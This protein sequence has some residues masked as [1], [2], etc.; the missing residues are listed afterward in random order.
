M[1]FVIL[2]SIQI[3]I[4]IALVG[5]ILVQRSEGG[6]LGMGGGPSG[7]MSARGAGNFLT[8]ATSIL[9][10]LFFANCIAL[11]VVSNLDRRGTSVVDQVGADNVKL[12]EAQ[13]SAA[14]AAAAQN[15][16]QSTGAASSSAAP[17]LT[18]LPSPTSAAPSLSTLGAPASSAASS[19]AARPA[20]KP[21][22]QPAKPA[23][24]SSSSAASS[25][26]SN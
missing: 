6:A 21:A 11:T 2:L 3:L 10:F 14:A 25:S 13:A 4:G 15:A 20:A 12:N 24:T 17:S 7:F 5:L 1:L 18:D 16:Q 22:A 26:A 23:A 19:S 8:K 9:A